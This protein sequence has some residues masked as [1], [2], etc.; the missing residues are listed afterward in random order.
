MYRIVLSHIHTHLTNTQPGST[1]T[2]PLSPEAIIGVALAG[3]VLFLCTVTSLFCIWYHC[4][5]ANRNDYKTGTTEFKITAQYWVQGSA[6]YKV[7][8]RDSTRSS[9]SR[10][11]SLSRSRLSSLRN[12]LGRRGKVAGD[13]ET[14]E[15]QTA[16]PQVFS[17]PL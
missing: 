2:L 12:S 7:T 16:Q 10:G 11:S 6:Q 13:G 8:R 5:R 9:W 14:Y 1:I 4:F 15:N 17:T 3:T